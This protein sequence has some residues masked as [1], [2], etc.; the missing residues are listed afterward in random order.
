METI[1]NRYVLLPLQAKNKITGEVCR[2]AYVAEGDQ[3]CTEGN[4]LLEHI[5]GNETTWS[6]LATN[7]YPVI[8]FQQWEFE[9][10]H[11]VKDEESVNK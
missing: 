6:L 10:I 5:N 8:S 7:N 11:A 2:L 1:T 3:W 9:T 4:L